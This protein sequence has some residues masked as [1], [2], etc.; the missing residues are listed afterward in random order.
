MPYALGIDT[1]GTYTDA[2]LID[3]DSRA[4]I[5]HKS[6]LTT[7]PDLSIGIENIFNEIK[8]YFYDIS[9]IVLSTTLA[10]NSVLEKKY[11]NTSLI[12]IG[13]LNTLNNLDFSNIKYIK[14]IT[15]GHDSDGYE[16]Q[17]LD[18]EEI[19]KY[20]IETKEYVTSYAISSYFSIRNNDHEKVAKSIVLSLTNY[21]CVCGYELNQTL[22]MYE[23]GIT[24]YLN[25]SLLSIIKKFINSIEDI[26]VKFGKHKKISILNCNGSI[27]TLKEATEKPI[28]TILS[29]PAASLLGASFV[30][31]YSSFIMVDIGGT[32][33][34]ISMMKNNRPLINLDGALI[35]NWKTKVESLN[36]KT[37]PFGGDSHIWIHK[38]N[39]PTKIN[40][41]FCGKLNIGPIKVIPICRAATIYKNFVNQLSERWFSDPFKFGIHIQP[42]TYYIQSNMKDEDIVE[43]IKNLT[44]EEIDI[45]KKIKK[46]PTSI[47]DIIWDMSYVPIKA[48]ESLVS[49]NM[50]NIIGLTPTDILHVLGEYNEW[51]TEASKLGVKI[52]S[53]YLGIEEEDFC[54]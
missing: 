49:K 3:I 33:T 5:L 52:V 10:T 54:K 40:E 20:I 53:K 39:D 43:N 27:S 42:I 19:K 45:Y 51:N 9:Y 12:M 37:I 13:D 29:G 25:S 15:G 17:K 34:D 50:I 8:D 22:D 28:L 44:K 38:K 31:N 14:K 26:L 47:L 30:T 7:Y 46:Q 11:G 24:A 16:S 1:G 35:N 41:E 36:I 21:P 18:V 32:S 2:V 23:R 4:I 48:I 6:V